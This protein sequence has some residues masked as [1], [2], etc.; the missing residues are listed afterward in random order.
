QPKQRPKAAPKQKT[1]SKGAPKA[2]PAPTPEQAR[3]TAN[4]AVEQRST[5][6]DQRRDTVILP[7][8]G[9]NTDT[10]DLRDL[11]SIP[12]AGN[13]RVSDVLSQFPGVT[14]DSTAG[15][16]FHIRNEH[17]NAQFRINGILLP[18]GVS[19]FAQILD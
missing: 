6:L 16:D 8:V 14:K 1:A 2:A 7:K 17:A 9:A 15:G 4:R 3:E 11:E 12:Q 13:A 5:A 10:K 18:D 19:G